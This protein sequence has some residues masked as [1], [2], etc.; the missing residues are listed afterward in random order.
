MP[1]NRYLWRILATHL[2]VLVAIV[3]FFAAIIVLKGAQQQIK[4][5]EVSDRVLER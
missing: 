1:S 4:S 2:A 5:A 3:S